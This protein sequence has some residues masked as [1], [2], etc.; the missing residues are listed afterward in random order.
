MKIAVA[1]DDKKMVCGH[2]GRC[3]GFII[4]EAEGNKVMGREYKPNDFTEHAKHGGHDHEHH[5]H[6][7]AG[8]G[9]PWI[10]E[11]LDGCAAL[12]SLGMGKRL[13]DDLAALKVTPIITDVEDADQAVQLYLEGKLPTFDSGAACRH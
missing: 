12:I 8:I 5:D 1:S 4:Y 11:A 2:V 13:W 7:V 6:H 3:Q 9:H 10:K